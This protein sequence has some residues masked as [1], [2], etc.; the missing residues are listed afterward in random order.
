MK[1]LIKEYL[2]LSIKSKKSFIKEINRQDK[3]IKQLYEITAGQQRLI[4]E[5][6]KESYKTKF[7]N[8][9]KKRK[10]IEKESKE[11]IDYLIQTIKEIQEGGNNNENR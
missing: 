3:C 1:N 9:H 4:E 6:N 5:Y 11:T 7:N 10:E 2:E 8:E